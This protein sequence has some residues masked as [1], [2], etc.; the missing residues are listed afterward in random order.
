MLARNADFAITTDPLDNTNF[1]LTPIFYTH[2]CI[3]LSADHP[4]AAK[5]RL[6]YQDLHNQKIIS[7]GRS[8]RC[9]R[10]NMEKYILG[11][12]LNVDI[13]AEI[14]DIDVALD[15]VKESNV[16]YLGYDYIAA[17]QRHPD[18]RWKMLDAEVSGQNMYI[19]SLKNTLPRKVCR[20][21]QNFYWH[22]CPYTT[23]I[24]LFCNLIS[25]KDEPA[26]AFRHHVFL[27]QSFS[28]YL[29]NTFIFT[30]RR[31]YHR[32]KTS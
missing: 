9:F 31:I 28:C 22:G 16:I 29:Q 21:L 13:F 8:F 19:A 27:H 20:D 17:M 10:N 2:Y 6:S 11:N 32:R 1:T 18:I 7:K 25:K 4:L 5:E 30:L 24:K 12:G 23:K 3:A 15:L 14:T 26:A